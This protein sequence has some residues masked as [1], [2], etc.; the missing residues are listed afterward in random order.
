M[1]RLPGCLYQPCHGELAPE[2][3][4]R[5]IIPSRAWSMVC[6]DYTFDDKSAIGFSNFGSDIKERAA[7]NNAPVDEQGYYAKSMKHNIE[8]GDVVYIDT[9][10]LW[11]PLDFAFYINH[12]GC[13]VSNSGYSA[14]KLD[15]ANRIIRYYEQAITSRRGQERPAATVRPLPPQPQKAKQQ[16]HTLNSKAVGRLLAAG[17]IY[18][19]NVKGYAETAKQ[20]GGEAADG[21][22]QVANPQSI[23]SLIALSSIVAVARL[24]NNSVG[25]VKSLEELQ[26]FLGTYKGDPK[27]LNNINVVKMNYI[28]RDSVE[29]NLLRKQFSSVKKD[30]LKSIAN[31]PEVKKRVGPD[32][33]LRMADGKNPYKWDVHHK[34]PLDDSGSNDFSNLVLISKSPEHSVFTTSQARITRSIASGGSTEVL[35]A[36]PK[37]IIYP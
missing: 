25:N 17:G 33:L 14:F 24:P 34:L 8:H 5:I 13:L 15:G 30:F 4:D 1:K 23:G 6:R 9:K 36:V 2:L 12:Q 32:D 35:W 16:L 19:Q 11:N 18:N 22:S 37:G 10:S 27:L 31:N 21:F 7:W 3:Y 28:R 26:H 29:R 20:L